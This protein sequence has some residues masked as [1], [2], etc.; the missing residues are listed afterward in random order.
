MCQ[1]RLSRPHRRPRFSCEIGRNEQA[2]NDGIGSGADTCVLHAAR[3]P[4]N[5]IAGSES[6]PARTASSEPFLLAPPKAAGPVVVRARF[7]LHDINDINDGAE[8]F[9]FSGVFSLAWQDPRQAFD[10]AVCGRGGKNLPGQVSGRRD[11]ARLVSSSRPGQRI[12]TIPKN[13]VVLRVR[14]D[15]LSTL[16]QA[17]NA[18]AESEFDMRRFP[19]DE[20]RLEAI[21]EVLGFGRDEVLLQVESDEAS[22]SQRGST[23][24]M[25]H[26]RSPASVRDHGSYA[27][28]QGCRRP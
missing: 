23:A 21:F 9:E 15:G 8:T 6:D 5:P 17:L 19:F 10:P 27:G 7:E 13:G 12:R 26:H 4:G 3:Q 22:P 24:A 28:H 11:L 1:V 2:H 18:T 20:H 14:P 25:D 16:I